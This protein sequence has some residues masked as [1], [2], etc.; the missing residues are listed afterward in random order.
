MLPPKTLSFAADR[1][2]LDQR[3]DMVSM[4]VSGPLAGLYRVR[5]GASCRVLIRENLLPGMP[6]RIQWLEATSTPAIQRCC[7]PTRV[8]ALFHITSWS[9]C[10]RRNSLNLKPA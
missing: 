8:K 9:I 3:E 6:S 7:R 2:V 1:N 5:E 10:Q 4:W